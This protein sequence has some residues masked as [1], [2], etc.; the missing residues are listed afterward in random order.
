[1]K[2]TIK[3]AT[4]IL[5]LVLGNCSYLKNNK[6]KSFHFSFY[7]KKLYTIQYIKVYIIVFIVYSYYKSRKYPYIITIKEE[8]VI[9][10]L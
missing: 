6:V 7:L 1:M 2:K 5:V 3:S 9:E 8:R 4:I 10:R